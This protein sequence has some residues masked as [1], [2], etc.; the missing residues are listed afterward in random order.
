MLLIDVWP[1]ER[2]QSTRWLRLIAEKLQMFAMALASSMITLAIQS[3]VG[4]VV[5]TDVLP[6][7]QRVTHAAIAYLQY[8]PATLWPMHLAFYYPYSRTLDLGVALVSATI[9]VVV[10]WLA[11]SSRHAKPFLLIGWLWYW[12][13]SFR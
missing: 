13:R 5:S 2:V 6:A 1:L 3:R 11:W 9:L 7:S 10:T 4:T 12:A 8:L